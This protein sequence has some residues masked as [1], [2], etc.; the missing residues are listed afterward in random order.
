MG[1]NILSDQLCNYGFYA[2]TRGLAADINEKD[3]NKPGIN[4]FKNLSYCDEHYPLVIKSK[5]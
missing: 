1:N 5:K 3:C 4:F 2:H